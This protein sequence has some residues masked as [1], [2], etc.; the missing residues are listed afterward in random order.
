MGIKECV[1]PLLQHRKLLLTLSRFWTI[2]DAADVVE[3]VSVAELA[4]KHF[5]RTGLPY[6]IA[7]DQ[8]NWWFKA[9]ADKL[10]VQIRKRTHAPLALSWRP[11]PLTRSQKVHTPIHERNACW[12][13]YSIFYH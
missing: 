1:W 5:A 11:H 3:T 12:S 9:L 6:R 8:A 10:E 2:I 7:V 13:A 4:A